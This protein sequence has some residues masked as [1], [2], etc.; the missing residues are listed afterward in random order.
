[1]YVRVTVYPGAKKEHIKHVGENR[2]EI[3]VREP[4]EQNL[5]NARI[6]ELVAEQYKVAVRQVRMISGHHSQRK[7][8]SIINQ[9]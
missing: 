9:A 7:I 5:A 8:L 6:L 4:A 1:M 2:F 3:Q